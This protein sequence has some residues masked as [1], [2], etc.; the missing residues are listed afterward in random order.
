M[1]KI[2]WILLAVLLIIIGF[3]VYRATIVNAKPEPK[4]KIN[5]CHAT[6]SDK[7]PWEAIQVDEG[8]VLVGKDFLYAGEIDDKGKPVKDG[9]KWCEK[10][11][12][13]D[14]CKNLVGNQTTLPENMEA[15]GDICGCVKGT[16][17]VSNA[18]L[19]K[20]EQDSFTCEK[21]KSVEVL[22][23]CDGSFKVTIMV[24]IPVELGEL[25]VLK[26]GLTTTKTTSLLL[27]VSIQLLNGNI[28]TIGT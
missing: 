7:N 14:L 28:K 18:T 26:L 15:D 23:S 24:E 3:L 22:G 5:I 9:E 10:N 25:R 13:I 12:P 16:H 17:E 2:F 21:D 8:S 11:E 4:A 19:N 27:P 6:G 1:K 20:T